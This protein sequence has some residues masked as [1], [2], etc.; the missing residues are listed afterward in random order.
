M[1]Y[2]SENEVGFDPT[3]ISFPSI[4]GCHAIIY[5]TA[6]GLFGLHNYGGDNPAQFQERAAVFRDFVRGHGQGNGAAKTMYGVCYATTQRGYG[7]NPKQN[8]LRE[9]VTFATALNFNGPLYGYNLANRSFLPPAYVACGKV[10][11]TCVIQVKPWD[12]GDKT[13]G[14]NNNPADYKM[15]ARNKNGVGYELKATKQRVVTAVTTAGLVTVYPEKLR[16]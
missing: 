7:T 13:E 14:P 3:D 8:W 16:G 11:D 10:G 12:E 9:L 6:N 1:V 5:V 2:L 4:R 15:I